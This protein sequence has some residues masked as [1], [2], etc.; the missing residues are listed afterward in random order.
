M[1]DQRPPLHKGIRIKKKRHS[2]R[3]SRLF[4]RHSANLI[5]I[6]VLLIFVVTVVALEEWSGYRSMSGT[7]S[8][9]QVSPEQ[10]ISTA[11]PRM[12]TGTPILTATP[13]VPVQIASPGAENDFQALLLYDSARIHDSDINFRKLAE[14]YG[15]RLQQ[16]DLSHT[17]LTDAV[18]K[19]QKGQYYLAIGINADTLEHRSPAFFRSEQIRLLEDAVRGGA[20]L[21]VSGLSDVATQYNHD[22]LRELTGLTNV[23]VDRPQDSHCDWLV[24]GEVPEVTREFS[25]QA[26]SVPSLRQTDFALQF[27]GSGTVVPLISSTDDKGQTYAITTKLQLGSGHIFLDGSF[28]RGNLESTFMDQLYTRA[29]FSTIIPSMLFLRS[30]LGDRV[31][32]NDHRYANLTI[33]DPPLWESYRGFSYVGLLQEMERHNFHTSIAFLPMN[34]NTSH[35]DVVDIFRRYSNRYSLV[36]H[37]NNHDGYEFYR[38]S[39]RADDPYTARPFP[40]QEADIREALERMERHTKATG[41]PYGK[42]MIFPYGISPE[43]TLILLKKYSFNMTVNGQDIPLDASPPRNYDFGMYQANMNYGNF[44]SVLRLSP[45]TEDYVFDFFVSKPALMYVHDQFFSGNMG[46]FNP[47]ADAIN[48]VGKVEWQSLD[49]IAKHLYLEKDN[50]D[51]S[52]DVKVYGNHFILPNDTDGEQIYHV[53]KEETLNVPIANLTVN[54]TTMQ[55]TVEEGQLRLDLRVPARSSAEV[56]I[57]YDTGVAISPSPRPTVFALP[58]PTPDASPPKV[59]ADFEYPDNPMGH[60]W[61]IVK[62]TGGLQTLYDQSIGSRV[63]FVSTQMGLSFQVEFGPIQETRRYLSARIK[64]KEN[65]YLYAQVEDDHGVSYYLQYST[66][67]GPYGVN[68]DRRY[69]T[70]YL[71]DASMG[72]EWY[73]MT[74]DLYADLYELLNVRLRY[75]TSIG[76]RGSC[77]VDDIVL[78]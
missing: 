16:I 64:T 42:I 65:V 1:M 55:Y 57:A 71:G 9:S 37:G 6:A 20:N 74:R 5:A 32:H 75:V 38:Y 78:K 34:W 18:L 68:R 51:G 58:T 56:N 45:S 48:K 22:V 13:T 66:G 23:T 52:K 28:Q 50:D 10:S 47:V 59:I 36:V 77:Y 27:G 69:V 72:G 29:G 11:T 44:A 26:I 7:R 4:S 8:V 2:R 54:G 14:Y 41:I 70:Y 76:L 30:S 46:A 43:D 15:V 31:W 53:T 73:T 49:Y 35:P 62:G 60:G 21:L 67:A 12:S 24:S 3:L 17:P 25:G 39:T 19:N 61:K 63:M 40:D 33:D